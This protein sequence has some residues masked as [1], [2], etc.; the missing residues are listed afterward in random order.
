M[1]HPSDRYLSC[2][3]YLDS[4]RK[5]GVS[6]SIP[7]P[8]DMP[9]TIARNYLLKEYYALRLSKTCVIV[10][11]VARIECYP[12]PL[13]TIYLFGPDLMGEKEAVERSGFFMPFPQDWDKTNGYGW[14]GEHLGLNK[15]KTSELLKSYEPYSWLQEAAK[16]IDQ[17][18]TDEIIRIAY[19]FVFNRPKPDG[20]MRAVG[21]EAFSKTA[22]N[23]IS[24]N[25]MRANVNHLLRDGLRC[26]SEGTVT[27]QESE[28]D[29]NE[30]GFSN[31]DCFKVGPS[32]NLLTYQAIHF[33]NM[34]GWKAN[35]ESLS[36]LLACQYLCSVTKLKAKRK[37]LKE[38][39][40]Y[41]QRWAIK[42][43][44]RSE[45]EKKEK[46]E[47]LK[48]SAFKFVKKS[49]NSLLKQDAI[50]DVGNAY[51]ALGSHV[52]TPFGKIT[53]DPHQYNDL[54]SSTLQ[55]IR[56]IH[57]LTE[58]KRMSLPHVK[59]HQ[60]SLHCKPI[61]YMASTCHDSNPEFGPTVQKYIKV[62]DMVHQLKENSVVVLGKDT[63]PEVDVLRRIRDEL[64]TIN[65]NAFLVR[66][67][68]DIP[69]QSPEEKVKLLTL[70]SKFT[71]MEDSTA[72]GHIAEFE[73]CKNNRVPLVLLRKKGKGS[74]WMI[75][76]AE[77]VDVNFIRTF[78]YS[79][80]HLH[81]VLVEATKWAEEFIHRRAD[82]YQ[83]YFPWRKTFKVRQ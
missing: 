23:T 63:S 68:K 78:E 72:S 70:M 30:N 2:F 52:E 56:E 60:Q 58:Q 10:N 79:E 54:Y 66:E 35:I 46:K 8:L 36:Y 71:V 21:L 40:S 27:I 29:L 74:T 14:S 1:F 9:A 42:S 39:S 53:M 4:L 33:L 49:V 61:I 25:F 76:D 55:S 59:S 83:G 81:E 80:D 6:L 65:Y 13:P 26:T 44:L 62:G 3:N 17:L 15:A 75:G 73:Y 32:N 64:R 45:L 22:V 77:L 5:K 12:Q 19:D 50:A 69:C 20:S 43:Q 41:N 48:K 7:S 47:K 34:Y 24:R 37:L 57:R 16:R 51:L 28:N 11:A 67:E 18:A 82:A 31:Q 38:S